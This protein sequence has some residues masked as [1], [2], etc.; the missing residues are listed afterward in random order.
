[1]VSQQRSGIT[2][3]VEWFSSWE[4]E[5][6]SSFNGSLQ[7]RAE[8]RSKFNGALQEKAESRSWR[9]VP[10]KKKAESRSWQ[11]VPLKK[12]SGI[13]VFLKM[14]NVKNSVF[15]AI[16]DFHLAKSRSWVNG[17]AQKKAES[18]SWVNGAAQK[19]AESRS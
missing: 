19:K 8:S 5:S 1:M 13:T 15:F 6:R 14:K 7:G 2:F 17:A 11:M 10:L 4:A 16:C 9:M 18:R 12:K 3:Q